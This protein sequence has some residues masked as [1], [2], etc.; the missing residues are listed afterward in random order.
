MIIKQSTLLLV[1]LFLSFSSCG[2]DDDGD[3]NNNGATDDSF[4]TATI[5][6]KPFTASVEIINLRADDQT[7]LRTADNKSG[8]NEY[9]FDLVLQNDKDNDP[10]KIR[11]GVIELTEGTDTKAWKLPDNFDYTETSQTDTHLE[12]TFSFTADAWNGVQR[13]TSDQLVITNGKFRANKK[14]GF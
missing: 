7:R 2:G 6:G 11:F 4:L 5:N 8:V 3:G 9:K 14:G 1:L 13:D 12:G 10:T